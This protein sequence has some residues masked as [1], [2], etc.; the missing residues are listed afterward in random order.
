MNYR[1][2]YMGPEFA[3]LSKT[4]VERTRKRTDFGRT[5]EHTAAVQA[6]KDWLMSYTVL[7]VPDPSIL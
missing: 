3:H 7:Q 6:L 4:L 1:R 5:S 2:M